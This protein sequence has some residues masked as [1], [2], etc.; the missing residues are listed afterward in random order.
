M[1]GV[2]QRHDGTLRV[3]A[4]CLILAPLTRGGHQARCCSMAQLLARK[5]PLVEHTGCLIV[6]LS[7]WQAGVAA[8]LSG[9]LERHPRR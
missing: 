4:S 7:N 1:H 9:S 2:R 6:G 3:F 8:F 5:P